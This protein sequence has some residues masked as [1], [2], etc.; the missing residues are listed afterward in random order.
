MSGPIIPAGPPPVGITSNF[1]DPVN[2]AGNLIACNVILLVASIIIV[3][4]R[5]L[6]RTVLTT[7]RLGWDDWTAIFSAFVIVST[8]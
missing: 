3:G 8:L 7:W 6:S 5:V 1:D 4:A 2:K